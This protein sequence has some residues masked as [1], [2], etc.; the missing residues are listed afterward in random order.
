MVVVL[1]K[2]RVAHALG[3]GSRPRVPAV[4]DISVPSHTVEWGLATGLGLGLRYTSL[5]DG[6]ATGV[7]PWLAWH[8]DGG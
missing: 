3:S 5:D 7:Q 1:V 2:L 6:G 8:R 4:A